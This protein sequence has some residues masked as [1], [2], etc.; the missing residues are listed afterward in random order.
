MEEGALPITSVLT[1]LYK[2]P[3]K[4]TR[5]E[6]K[7]SERRHQNAPAEPS[8]CIIWFRSVEKHKA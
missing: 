5:E 7:K 6:R 8:C 4:E 3:P 2:S 1:V